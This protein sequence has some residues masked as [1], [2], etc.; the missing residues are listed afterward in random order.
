[1]QRKKTPE[2]SA[3]GHT[4]KAD[5]R[6]T[7]LIRAASLFFLLLLSVN[8]LYAFQ[9]QPRAV[10][11]KV[12]REQG[13]P[14][15]GASI[16]VKG[17]KQG[18][19]TDDN[20]MFS[21][22]VPDGGQAVLIISYIGLETAEYKVGSQT[23]LDVTLK[24]AGAEQKEVVV[25]GYGT[26]RKSDITG[27]VASVKPKDLTGN[28]TH[29]VDQALQ[30]RVAGVMV[31]NDNAAPNSTTTI[32][33][34]GINSVNGG[35]DPLVVIDGMQLGQLNT[36]DPNEVESIEVLKDA[37]ATSIYGARGANGVIIVT[38]KKGKKG[39]PAVAYNNYFTFSKVR[40]RLD[41]MNA[42]QYAAS[43]NANRTDLGLSRV[44]SD[45]DLEKF[46]N[47]STDWQS[48]IY[49]NGFTQNHQLSMSGANEQTSYYF[50]ADANN[51]R[52][53]IKG[54]SFQGYSIRSNVKTQVSKRLSAGLNLFINRNTDHPSIINTYG[55]TT[56][57][58]SPVFAASHFAPVKP[59][60]DADGNY[61]RPG[62][63]YGPP[64]VSNP[65]ALAVEPIINN[66][67]NSVNAVADIEYKITPELKVNVIGAALTISSENNNFFNA[68]PTGRTGTEYA[69]I[70]NSRSLLLQN[71]NMLTYEK[72]FGKHSLK[73]TGVF[74]QQQYKN[75]G[76]TAGSIGFL[77][78]SVTYFNLG[79]GNNPQIPSS[80]GN[81]TA[82]LSYMARINYA[83]DSRYS[84]TLTGR[85]DGS[86][87]FGADNKWGYFPSVGFGWN[88]SNEH[89]YGEGFRK[90]IT[91]LKLRGSYGIVGNQ[92]ISP[93]QS[94][95]SLNN[96][97]VYILNGTTAST[98]VGLGKIGNPDLKWEKTRQLNI[99]ID[100]QLLNGRIDF[101]ADYYEK[102]ISDLLFN[103]KLPDIGGGS[104]T[105]LRNVGEMQNK[106]F[107][108]YLGGKI[109]TGSFKW[110]T[111]FTYTQNRNKLTNLYNN[112]KELTLGEP[113]LPGFGNTLW[114]ELGQPVGLFRGYQMNG[115]WKSSEAE[116]AKVYDAEPGYPKYVDQNKDNKIDAND[117]IDMGNAQPKFIAGWN[118][119]FSFKNF[120][121]N[122]FVN[123]VQGN[124]IYNISRVRTERSSGDGD[125]TS[126]KILDR[127]TPDHENTSVP[128]FKGSSLYEIVQSTRWLEDGSYLRIKTISLGYNVPVSVLSRFKIAALRIYASANN[129]VT[130]TNY[131][132]YD[133]EARTGVDSRGGID[134]ATYP[135]QKSFIVGLNLK[136]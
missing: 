126:T 122:V 7:R 78:N 4:K 26:Q 6:L 87:V 9:G 53:I 5:R 98:G 114:L 45:A 15:T 66:L 92:A 112:L 118:N 63:G 81:T 128:S 80:Y 70:A 134:L 41:L 51:Q 1:M 96:S 116:Q 103:V 69:S 107:E 11:G 83:Y 35:N 115:L 71:T 111:G 100:M 19:V 102:K 86:S 13:I 24:E 120:D 29:R 104:G 123:A 36:L 38:T 3:S 76:S 30:G 82:L 89:F 14:L 106:G 110:E 64:S 88:I 52:G 95:A 68:K 8:A 27:A 135:S 132:G 25:V 17:S 48:E 72:G 47:Q 10:K 12:V 62:G 50:S 28:A 67:M 31:Q 21:I 121:L 65:L 2:A 42:E 58:G 61:S 129:L 22:S 105:I 93:Y 117:I 91:S 32:R 34:R 37:S 44:F 77:T 56:N 101:I 130:F 109:L 46:K 49:R 85:S 57:S 79:L 99:G 84:L 74:E 23:Y 94:L 43:V 127:W 119:S 113:G 39:Q 131:T 97:L 18:T 125:A 75:N 40:K 55:G 90:A 60:Y 73:L 54:S 108:L 136:F 16:N 124:K 133:P 33:I 20:G 59:V